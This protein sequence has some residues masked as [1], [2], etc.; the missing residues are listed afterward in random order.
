MENA[1][2]M[3]LYVCVIDQVH[4]QLTMKTFTCLQNPFLF[5]YTTL[6]LIHFCM[7]LTDFLTSSEAVYIFIHTNMKFEKKKTI[8]N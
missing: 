8:Q 1:I 4:W 5:V 7:Y 2:V 6:M 3:I